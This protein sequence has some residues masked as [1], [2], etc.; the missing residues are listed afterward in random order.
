MSNNADCIKYPV[1]FIKY[2]IMHLLKLNFYGIYNDIRKC[3]SSWQT[4]KWT[5]I[6]KIYTSSGRSFWVTY[7]FL[8]YFYFSKGFMLGNI[9]L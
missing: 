6:P 4:S 7:I 2:N 9:L 5:K 8:F 3:S 1:I